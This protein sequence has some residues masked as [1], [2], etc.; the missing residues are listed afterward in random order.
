MIYSPPKKGLLTIVIVALAISLCSATT[1]SASPATGAYP[2]DLDGYKTVSTVE[3]YRVVN[4]WGVWF[5]TGLGLRCAIEDDGSFGCTGEL[6]GTP[7]GENEVAWFI[8]DTFPRLYHTREPRFS[9][10]HAQMPLPRQTVIAYRG[11]R[12]AVTLHNT[13]YCIHGNDPDSQFMV[14]TTETLRG[15]DALPAV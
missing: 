2:E 3:T 6:S 11:S 13:V 14:T 7:S 5:T 9:S 15:R 4:E 8:G 12:C 1:A 10:A